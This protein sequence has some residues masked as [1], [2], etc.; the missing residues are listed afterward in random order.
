MPCRQH[1]AVPAFCRAGGACRGTA[2]KAR[3]GTVINP[4]PGREPSLYYS[5]RSH[6]HGADVMHSYFEKI[7][8]D[9][10][11]M[12]GEDAYAEEDAGG[13]S[14]SDIGAKIQVEI[15]R[16]DEKKNKGLPNKG[17]G[18][19]LVSYVLKTPA[20]LGYHHP[21]HGDGDDEDG[22]DE[23][24]AAADGDATTADNM[25]MSMS[26]H[27]VDRRV[28][29]QAFVSIHAQTAKVVLYKLTVPVR[30]ALD[31]VDMLTGGGGGQTAEKGYESGSHEEDD[32]EEDPE[33]DPEEEDGGNERESQKKLSRDHPGGHGEAKQTKDGPL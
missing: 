21:Q 28:L 23:N 17:N 10:A 18:E 11:D 5:Y 31:T 7:E 9:I 3:Q 13:D 26:Y 4:T 15:E 2:R 12:F 30:L 29:L 22:D 24:S 27:S 6:S 14:D 8:G 25:M 16:V 33:E 19:Y 32:S 1:R 20:G